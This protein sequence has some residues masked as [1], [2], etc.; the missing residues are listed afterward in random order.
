MYGMEAYILGF[1]V[2]TA[3]VVRIVLDVTSLTI[4]V[5]SWIDVAYGALFTT[6]ALVLISSE[7]FPIFGYLSLAIGLIYFLLHVAKVSKRKNNNEK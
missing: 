3:L 6:V 5:G 2:L 7:T 1:V 4:K